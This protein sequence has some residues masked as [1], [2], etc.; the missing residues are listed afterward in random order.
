MQVDCYLNG[1][2][3]KCGCTTTALQ[4]ANKAC[5]KPCYP[6]MMNKQQWNDFNHG[7]I[8]TDNNG[9][10]GLRNHHILSNNSNELLI[11]DK[12]LVFYPKDSSVKQLLLPSDKKKLVC[13]IE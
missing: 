2:C 4:M 7:H 12:Y 1:V 10:W 11:K 5:D 9:R 6:E 3:T 8:I 13:G